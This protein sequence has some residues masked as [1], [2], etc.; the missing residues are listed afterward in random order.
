MRFLVATTNMQSYFMSVSRFFGSSF[1]FFS[2]FEATL[3]VLVVLRNYQLCAPL[4]LLLAMHQSP[5]GAWAQT[6]VS[7]MQ[8]ICFASTQLSELYLSP[9]NEAVSRQLY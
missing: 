1:L 4:G 7:H 9:H 8:N 2:C 6:W 5:H 3:V